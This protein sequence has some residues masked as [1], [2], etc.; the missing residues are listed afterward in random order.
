M[1][2]PLASV[3]ANPAAVSSAVGEDAAVHAA[4]AG[5]AHAG[6]RHELERNGAF[7]PPLDGDA[8]DPV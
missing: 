5:I 6:R 2:K 8:D 4:R 3:A 1:S 7:V